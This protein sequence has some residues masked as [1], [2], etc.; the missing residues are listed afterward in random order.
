MGLDLTTVR[1]TREHCHRCNHLS[2]ISFYSPLWDEVAG[3]WANDV[4]CVRCFAVLG[5]ERGIAWETDIVFYPTSLVTLRL[6]HKE[7]PN[8]GPLHPGRTSRGSRRLG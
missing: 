1:P 5:D 6:T 3:P 4:L 8:D 2:P 7:T